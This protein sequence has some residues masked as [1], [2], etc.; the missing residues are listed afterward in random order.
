MVRV[1]LRLSPLRKNVITSTHAAEPKEGLYI[2]QANGK[3][4][5]LKLSFLKQ[6]YEVGHRK[7]ITFL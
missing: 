2:Q 6:P 3:H 1:L 7:C 5:H 4:P